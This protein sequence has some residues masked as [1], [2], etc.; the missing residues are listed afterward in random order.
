MTNEIHIKWNPAL[1]RGEW[2]TSTDKLTGAD[3]LVTAVLISLMSDRVAQPNDDIPDGTT[4]RRGHWTDEAP[5]YVGSRLWLL[6]RRKQ[7][8]KTLHDAFAYI[9]E[10]LQWLIDDKVVARFGITVQWTQKSML[11]AK[12]T[13]YK[14]DGSIQPMNF[15]WAWDGLV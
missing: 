3:D 6:V 14:S 11:G 2:V 9:Q 8:N 13:A 7:D 15:N 10:A 12:V 4:D 1:G 5:Y